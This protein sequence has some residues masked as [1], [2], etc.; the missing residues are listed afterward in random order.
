MTD[1]GETED[2]LFL[3]GHEKVGEPTDDDK[4]L[5]KQISETVETGEKTLIA[6]VLSSCGMEKIIDCE[7]VV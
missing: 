4:K 6:I 1:S 3:P 7:E 2:D 5:S